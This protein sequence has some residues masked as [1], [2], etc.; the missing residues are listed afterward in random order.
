MAQSNVEDQTFDVA[1]VGGGISGV[2]AAWRLMQGPYDGSALADIVT[3]AGAKP[4]VGLFEVSRRIGGRLFSVRLP[5]L[6]DIPV[7]LGGMRF[8]ESHRRVFGLIQHLGLS[9]RELPINDPNNKTLFYLRGRHFTAND[10]GRP[11]F[12][13]PYRLDRGERARSPGSLLIEVALR[14]V[15]KTDQLRNIG[16]WNLL[17]DE[18]SL[19]AYQL[20][21]EAGGY[22]TIVHNW[23]AAEAIPF[24]L[25]DFAPNARYL[26]LKD[27]FQFLPRQLAV[28]FQQSGGTIAMGHR[29]HR[30]DRQHDGWLRL[31]FDRARTDPP[32]NYCYRRV[33]E[34]TVYR[35]RHL[36]L[37][38]PRRALELLHPDSYL[39]SSSQFETDLQS[40]L[41]QPGFKIFAAYRSP[42]WF[43]QRGV[44]AG[45]SVTDLPLRQC[46]YWH[47]AEGKPSALM[48]SYNDGASVEYWSGLARETP[49]YVPSPSMC[50]PGVPIPDD[51]MQL[52]ASAPLVR[53]LQNQ[54][55]ELHG[56]P[57][58]PPRALGQV[59]EPY[60]AVFQNWTQDPFGGGWHFWKIGANAKVIGRRM[61]HPIPEA[62]I[63][64]CGE[65][66]SRQQG[67]VEGALETAD[68]LL[69]ENLRLAPPAW[70]NGS[71][72]NAD[73]SA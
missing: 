60:V 32:G 18:L 61:R 23:S 15:N 45:R 7:E 71:A 12:T 55:R 62:P 4:R 10:W 25:A 17:L 22:D 9:F 43:E 35:A 38:M 54:L 65:A 19:E 57:D 33:A 29:L 6:E 36:I 39:F 3:K 2:Y 47:T 68:A 34:E 31:T 52:S 73:S 8:L 41:P 14:H 51:V 28:Q 40:V 49:R 48:A 58:L 11:E 56:L 50:P 72:A 1:V 44:R 69:E 37:A 21:R 30:I 42:W 24:L 66:W 46:Y 64:I 67:W 27:G 5:G 16:F 53:E 63:Y 13:P 70:R 59:P 20:L 26:V